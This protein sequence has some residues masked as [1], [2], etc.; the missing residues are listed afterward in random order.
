MIT[1]KRG[2]QIYLHSVE[3]GAW[4]H[5]AKAN[6]DIIFDRP[7]LECVDTNYNRRSFTYNYR[8][9]YPKYFDNYIE[10]ITWYDNI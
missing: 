6:R 8:K 3:R 5:I 4:A 1:L 2:T 10:A 9:P 7:E